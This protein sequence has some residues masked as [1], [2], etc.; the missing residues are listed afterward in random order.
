MEK[1]SNAVVPDSAA[2]A[3][4]E[5]CE[6]CDDSGLLLAGHIC[7]LCQGHGRLGSL[8][9]ERPHLSKRARGRLLIERMLRTGLTAHTTEDGQYIAAALAPRR[10]GAH[11]RSAATSQPSPP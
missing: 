5:I 3:A 9:W 6:A 7:P 2:D 4:E 1:E 8:L 11:A 10:P